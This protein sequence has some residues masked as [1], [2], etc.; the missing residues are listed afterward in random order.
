MGG[1]TNLC[2]PE[3][4]ATANFVCPAM[5]KRIGKQTLPSE[6][7]ARLERRARVQDAPELTEE[8]FPSLAA[9]S[10]EDQGAQSLGAS[11][12]GFA[13]AVRAA[14]SPSRDNNAAPRQNISSEQTGSWDDV[15][16]SLCLLHL[17]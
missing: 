15:R 10:S 1:R 4:H 2:V 16:A 14:G 11:K 6:S 9:G 12:A 8:N 3:Q 5:N 7:E 13:N 17:S